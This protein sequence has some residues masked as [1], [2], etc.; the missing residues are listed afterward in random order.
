MGGQIWVESEGPEKGTIA[1]FLVKLG[2]CNNPSDAL[3][4]Q[5]VLEGHTEQ[6]STEYLA[7]NDGINSTFPYYE[8]SF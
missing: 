2:M 6:G 1:T 5:V 3:V 7:N 4:Q 8:R